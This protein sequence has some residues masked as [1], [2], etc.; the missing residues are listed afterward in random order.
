MNPKRLMQISIDIAEHYT[1]HI[2]PNG[3]KAQVV[4]FTRKACVIVKKHLDEMIDSE[5]SDIIYTGALNDNDEMRKYHYTEEEKKEKIRNYKNPEHPLK[6]LI[7][8]SMLLT[9]FDAPVEQAMYLDRPLRDH[10]LLQAIARTNRPYNAKK[11][12]MILDYCGILKNLRNALN[13]D[14]SEI[15]K[16]LIDFDEL[17]K[18]LPELIHKFKEIFQ[19]VDISNLWKCL[20]HIDKNNLEYK[21]KKTFKELQ[22]T[23]ETI[24]PDPYVLQYQKDYKWTAE[25]MVALNQF[26]KNRKPDI[27]T[28]L[29]NTRQ[30]IQQHIDLS[31]INKTTP[32]FVVDDNYLRRIDELPGDNEQKEILIEKRLRSIL[33]VRIN[34]LPVYKTLME[35]L[36]EIIKSKEEATQEI[37][38][39]L[40]E[41]TGDINKAIKEEA[42]GK[43]KGEMAIN[44]LVKEKFEYKKPEELTEK[45]KKVV[46]ERIFPGWQIQPSVSA[47]IKREI[48]LEIAKYAKE[49]PEIKMDPDDYSSFSRE[50]MKYVERHF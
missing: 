37:L 22:I 33:R 28:Y 43:S 6:L 21:V 14:E 7:V 12:G 32:V 11:C 24:A 29:V 23:Y 34:N 36:D 41:L 8:Q 27:S 4:C 5:K 18:T 30:L 44:Q 26:Q 20:R 45:I 31:N 49:H 47:D 1:R 17:K 13:F 15:E 25:I 2:E 10:T 46:S 19:G 42:L 48:I 9:G 39:L 35:R 3:F 38:E 16:C 50:A 40:K